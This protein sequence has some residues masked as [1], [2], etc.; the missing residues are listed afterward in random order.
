[1]PWR[2]EDQV[3]VQCYP[4]GRSLLLRAAGFALIGIGAV[5]I[6]LCVPGWAWAALLGAALIL[7]GLLL[8]R[9]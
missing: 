6:I 8:V 2:G 7:A 4:G 9:K 5:L 3:R 1:M